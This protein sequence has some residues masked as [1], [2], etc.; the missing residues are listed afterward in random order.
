MALLPISDNTTNLA[1]P[2]LL[3]FLDPKQGPL[4]APL[5]WSEA[6]VVLNVPMEEGIFYRLER[7]GQPLDLSWRR[8]EGSFKLVAEWPRSDAGP[9]G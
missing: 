1:E 3:T 6:L 5:E 7:Q 4:S 9:T 2:S 8:L